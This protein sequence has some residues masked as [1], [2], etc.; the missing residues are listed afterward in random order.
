ME[1]AVQQVLPYATR[2]ADGAKSF[3]PGAANVADKVASVVA[4]GA[5]ALPVY[6]YLVARLAAE[7]CAAAAT[8]T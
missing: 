6:K 7:A 1:T 5:D 8:R 3:V 4:T 2:I